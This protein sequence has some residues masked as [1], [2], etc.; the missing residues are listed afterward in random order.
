MITCQHPLYDRESLVIL[1]DHVTA[2]AGTGV[3]I[4]RQASV[5][6]TFLSARNTALVHIVM[7]MN[8]AA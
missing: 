6:M 2:D 8:T 3:Y 1:G 4:R 7:S 5:R